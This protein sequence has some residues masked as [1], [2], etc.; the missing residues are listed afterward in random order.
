MGKRVQRLELVAGVSGKI[1]NSI[2]YPQ[3]LNPN[4]TLDIK[5][6]STNSNHVCSEPDIPRPHY[7]ALSGFKYFK[8]ATFLCVEM[9]NGALERFLSL[10]PSLERLSVFYCTKLSGLRAAGPSVAV[11]LKYLEI[12]G[13]PALQSIEICDANLVSLSYIGREISLI[14]KKVPRLVE[15]NIRY[16]S[17]Q[18][19]L[20]HAFTQLSCCLPQLEVLRLTESMVSI[21]II[22]CFL[23]LSVI[24]VPLHL[25][26]FVFS[27]TTIIVIFLYLQISPPSFPCIFVVMLLRYMLSFLVSL[28]FLILVTNSV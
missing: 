14:L 1:Q 21:L 9:A 17:E 13:C 2:T 5:Q 11:A 28:I 22:I 4:R 25:A 12:R 6:G 18:D 19:F 3:N 24:L 8:A 26:C 27:P 10:C 23:F 16:T 7:C 15:A 20:M